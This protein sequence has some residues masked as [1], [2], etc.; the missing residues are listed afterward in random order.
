MVHELETRSAPTPPYIAES[1]S[2]SRPTLIQI[3]Y[4]YLGITDILNDIAG[5]LPR[6]CGAAAAAAG[7]AAA[8]LAV[9]LRRGADFCA[10]C[11]HNGG[12]RAPAGARAL[13]GIGCHTLAVFMEGRAAAARI[14]V[15]MG[16]QGAGW[17]GMAPF[18]AAAP[19]AGGANAAAGIAA[20]PV[21]ERTTWSRRAY[22]RP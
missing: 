17:I 14:F 6:A 18:L 11:P 4:K 10:G 7:L 13:G 5:E 20:A 2:E 21:S 12:T 15:Q 1:I 19:A 3:V 9:G 16:G 22:Q 8:G